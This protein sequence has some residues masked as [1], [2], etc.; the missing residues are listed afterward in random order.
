MVHSTESYQ[1]EVIDSE[2]GVGII[3]VNFDIN[4]HAGIFGSTDELLATE[5]EH[6]EKSLQALYDPSYT[7]VKYVKN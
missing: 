4:A 3:S 7:T 6:L 5:I 2:Q 1:F